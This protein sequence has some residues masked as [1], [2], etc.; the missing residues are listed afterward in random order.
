MQ[1]LPPSTIQSLVNQANTDPFRGLFRPI[2]DNLTIFPNLTE[3]L[4]DRGLVA[5]IPLLAG[6]TYNEQALFLPFDEE[7]TVAPPPP[8]VPIPGAD[9]LA[10]GIKR[11][12]DRRN[13]YGNGL[14]SYRY[15]FSG[16]FSNI[17]PRY[18]LGGMHSCKW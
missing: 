18:W 11:E 3:R 6:F 4:F 2:A 14:R 16:N 15:L 7:M 17:T 10:C 9:G 8:A 1:G 12:I 5:K 13:L